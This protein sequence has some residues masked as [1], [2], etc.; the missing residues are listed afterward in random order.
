M[1]PKFEPSRE[2]KDLHELKSDTM[3]EHTLSISDLMARVKSNHET[4][5]LLYL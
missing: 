4:V 2:S 5:R 1:T 3:D